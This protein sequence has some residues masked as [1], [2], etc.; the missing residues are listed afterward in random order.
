MELKTISEIAVICATF[1]SAISMLVDSYVKIKST[2]SKNHPKANK[3]G[4]RK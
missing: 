1:A 3:G 2:Q 4:K